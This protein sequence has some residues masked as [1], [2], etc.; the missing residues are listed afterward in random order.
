MVIK[1]LKSKKELVKKD[2]VWMAELEVGNE[3]LWMF[4]QMEIVWGRGIF[5]VIGSEEEWDQRRRE[6]PF[7]VQGLREGGNYDN[8]YWRHCHSNNNSIY[9][10]ENG[11][12]LDYQP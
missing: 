10:T 3:C 6:W 11:V 5:Q 9:A 4:H 8:L 12:F 1:N 2:V 7:L